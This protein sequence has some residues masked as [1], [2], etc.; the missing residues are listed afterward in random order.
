[1]MLL[2]EPRHVVETGMRIQGDEVERL[3]QSKEITVS[4]V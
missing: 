3:V 2:P 4:S 1:M